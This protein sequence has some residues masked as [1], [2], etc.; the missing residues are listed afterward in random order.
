M[1]LVSDLNE[2]S[3][4]LAWVLERLAGSLVI[5]VIL[6]VARTAWHKLRANQK[7]ALADAYDYGMYR[8]E[9]R[10]LLLPVCRSH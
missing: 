4:R 8:E 1:S 10:S 5:L 7:L 6:W 9:R 3:P 2:T